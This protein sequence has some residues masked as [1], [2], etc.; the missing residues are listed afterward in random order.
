M[1]AMAG[2]SI[3]PVV[4]AIAISNTVYQLNYSGTVDRYIDNTGTG[5]NS[6]VTMFSGTYLVDSSSPDLWP[7]ADTGVYKYNADLSSA[8]NAGSTTYS[9]SNSKMVVRDN[10]TFSNGNTYDI[11][12]VSSRYTNL[13]TN[14]TTIWGVKLVDTSSTALDSS[15]WILEPDITQ[16]TKARFFMFSYDLLDMSLNY[17]IGGNLDVL[18]DPPPTTQGAGQVKLAVSEPPTLLLFGA[19]LL[20]FGFTAYRKKN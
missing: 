17:F 11:Y 2:L 3:S 1:M 13:D 19:A 12:K 15:A 9:S 4:S 6:D 7:E 18:V 14:E 5:I 8:F 20:A 10:K 16:F